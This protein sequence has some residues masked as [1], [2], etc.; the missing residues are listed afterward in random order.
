MFVNREWLLSATQLGTSK[1]TKGD[2]A[3]CLLECMFL[4]CIVNRYLAALGVPRTS[5][6]KRDAA[7]G[8]VTKCFLCTFFFFLK[9]N[10][11]KAEAEKESG[12]KEVIE[13]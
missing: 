6:V 9:K 5:E 12:I 4:Y 7:I 2:F 1:M 8:Q 3:T 13:W 11:C 10:A